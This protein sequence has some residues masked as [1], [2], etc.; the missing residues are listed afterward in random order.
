M[1]ITLTAFSVENERKYTKYS[2]RNTSDVNHHLESLWYVM[3][4]NSSHNCLPFL[5]LWSFGAGVHALGSIIIVPVCLLSISPAFLCFLR[6]SLIIIIGIISFFIAIFIDTL[7][8]TPTHTI[9]RRWNFF[10][11]GLFLFLVRNYFRA[12]CWC[13]IETRF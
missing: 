2:K 12:F 9:L 10:L 4:L 6:N 3:R 5:F 7:S 1:L 8:I 13:S 11:D